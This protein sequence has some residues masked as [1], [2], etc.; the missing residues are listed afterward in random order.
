MQ[1]YTIAKIN[2]IAYAV[3]A[4]GRDMIA[5]TVSKTAGA[6]RVFPRISARRPSRNGHATPAAAIA[7]FKLMT[8]T[9]AE[10]AIAAADRAAELEPAA[11]QSKEGGSTMGS[12]PNRSKTN[13]QAK[14]N[15]TPAE[16]INA[17]QAAGDTQTQAAARIYST[18]RAWQDWETEG[19]TNR[20]MHP[21]LFEL[22]MLKTRLRTLGEVLD[23]QAAAIA[24]EEGRE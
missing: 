2:P 10:A 8:R 17:R 20:R 3:L 4:G 1:P 12:H 21:G 16:I 14:A 6:W 18:L 9:A 7:S 13:R 23:E 19:Q 15:P 5:A 11:L 22:Y 24:A